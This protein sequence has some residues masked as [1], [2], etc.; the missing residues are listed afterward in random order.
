[1][2]D[3]RRAEVPDLFDTGDFEADGP[4]RIYPLL[5]DPGN[6][7]LLV[8]WLAGADEFD[9]VR[10]PRSLESAS[11][12]LCVIDQGALTEHYETLRDR[13]ESEEPVLLPYLLLL[14]ADQPEFLQNV[15]GQLPDTLVKA[16]IDEM[17]SLPVRQFELRW[18]IESLLR[19][20]EQTRT[21]AQREQKLR[22][23]RRAVTAAGQAIYITDSEGTI[24]FVNSA[25]ERITGYSEG[26]AVGETPQILNSGEMDGEFYESLWETIQAGEVWEE[27]LTDLRKGGERYQARQTIAPIR[28]RGGD[29]DGY[30]AIQTD[31][32][33]RKESEA[34]RRQYQ[35]AIESSSD[36]LAAV[37]TE[38]RYL[39]ANG[40][41]REYHDTEDG[42]VR[43]RGMRALLDS[44]TVAAIEQHLEAARNGETVQFETTRTHPEKGER[45]LD[46][47]Y[48]PL[49][50]GD[51]TIKGV[52]VS[53]RDV[54]EA[55]ERSRRLQTLISDLPGIVYRCH[56][57]PGWPMEY[58]DGQC[59]AITGYDPEALETGDVSWGTELIHPGDRERVRESVEAAVAGDEAFELNYRIRTAAGETRW[60]HEHG[61]RVDPLTSG[62]SMLEG[63]ITDITERKERE[64]EL[65]QK[66]RAVDEAPVG[67]V[68]TDPAQ[69]DNP[70]RYVNDAF[71]EMTGYDEAEAIG[72]NCRF[73]QGDNTDPKTVARLRDRIDAEKPV[74]VT[75]RNY[76]ADGSEFWNHLEIAP[77][78]NGDGEVINYVGFQQDV[79]E[80][81]ER[82]RQLQIIDRV[83]RHNLHND[84]NV[85]QGMAEQIQTEGQDQVSEYAQTIIETGDAL[86][87]TMDKEREIT[88][89]LE[90]E[91]QRDAVDLSTT[92]GQSVEL[93]REELPA[94]TIDLA[95]PEGTVVRATDQIQTAITELLR[96][97][98]EH[99]EHETPEVQVSVS[100]SH[101]Q[102]ALQI[103]DNGPG[104]PKMERDM[105]LGT[106][107]ESPLYH[108]KGMGLWLVQLIVRRSNGTITF[109][110]NEPAGSIVTLSLSDA[111]TT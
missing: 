111:E 61:R 41:Y 47:V 22:Q 58:V 95:V 4:A 71:T 24:R 91:P 70:I 25:F 15:R 33:D 48:Y 18:R 50:D 39:F 78:R 42:V 8:D 87:Q 17:L 55:K 34:K 16:T 99:N 59:E 68:I 89:L 54:T 64:L 26:E 104:I 9:V 63:F 105:L 1:M 11:F 44:E 46:V 108:G 107:E 79:T 40:P 12:D 56:N 13:K 98:V 110:A 82:Q 38:N 106:E 109:G 2:P 29:I 93:I 65:H 69:A 30:V 103:S 43:G 19:M 37:D 6:E 92:L 5:A 84:L 75:I 102:V 23:F 86:L 88:A 32:T 3:N 101:G 73:L 72:R 97:A 31:I 28:G 80:L 60:V 49:V 7:Q 36:L 27:E 35:Q 14:P 66:T 81:R 21:L 20:R 10:Q 45:V 52:T 51:G 67:I 85:V 62:E 96:N 94:A 77:V 76:R 90:E 100:T 83:L 53:M 57:E 74:S